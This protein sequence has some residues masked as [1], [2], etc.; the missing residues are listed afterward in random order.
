M[1]TFRL[2]RDIARPVGE[3]FGFLRDFR[4]M[5]LWQSGLEAVQVFP[6]APVDIGSVIFE[7][8]RVQGRQIDLAYKV[9]ALEPDRSISLEST[10]GPVQ[11]SAV[12]TLS[13]ERDGTRLS[14]TL[15]VQLDGPMRLLAGLLT[16]AIRRQAEQDLDRLA[17]ALDVGN[18]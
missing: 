11:Y 1:A 12:Q 9:V 4:N 14:L 7:R 13:P 5:P 2:E 18:P 6:N 17:A 10:G 15:E 3:V 8:R 16:P